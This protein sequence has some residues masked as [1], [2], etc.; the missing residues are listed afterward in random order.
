M[1]YNADR[2]HVITRA[3]AKQST[4]GTRG[5]KGFN[6]GRHTFKFQFND[7]PWGSNCSFGLCT[8]KAEMHCK[9]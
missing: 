2:P 1:I 8:A 6:V 9:G 4:D 7:K 5:F 3:I